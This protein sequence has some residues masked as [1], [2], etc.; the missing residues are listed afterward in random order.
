MQ[1]GC[2][3]PADGSS[4]HSQAPGQHECQS[5]GNSRRSRGLSQLGLV[6][7]GTPARGQPGR[8]AASLGWRTDRQQRRNPHEEP[9]L[10]RVLLK[11]PGPRETPD[12]PCSPGPRRLPH[13]GLCRLATKPLWEVAVWCSVSNC[14]GPPPDDAPCLQQELRL[15][16][17]GAATGPKGSLV[18]RKEHRP[19]AGQKELKP[20]CPSHPRRVISLSSSVLSN[21]WS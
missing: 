18:W 10:P 4:L 16:R 19:E 13:S 15:H 3:Q 9:P 20:H 11:L 6:R 8:R 14:Q 2:S 5:E 12:R 21:R 7:Q 17:T 1:R